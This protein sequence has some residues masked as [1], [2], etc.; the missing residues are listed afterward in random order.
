MFNF[1][2]LLLFTLVANFGLVFLAN[3]E[4]SL[5]VRAD[6][7]A[8]TALS[9][10]PS[11]VKDSTSFKMPIL[12]LGGR[13]T[14]T[15]DF[16][17][18]LEVSAG[19][20]RDSVS[21]KSSFQ[22]EKAAFVVPNF[23]IED[24]SLQYGLLGN[25]WVNLQERESWTSASFGAKYNPWAQRLNYLSRAD[26]GLGIFRAEDEYRIELQVTNG[27]GSAAE[28]QG[29]RKDT[30][31]FVSL[32]PFESLR[33]E[34]RLLFAAYAL[35]GAYENIDPEVAGRE[36]LGI[37]MKFEQQKR[38]WILLEALST[39]DPA[40]GINLKVA[41]NVDVSAQGG[42]S[43]RGS[44][45]AGEIAA[46]TSEKSLISYRY[47]RFNPAQGVDAKGL[48]SGLLGIHYF[49]RQFLQ[50]SISWLD[51]HLDANHAAGMRDSAEFLF[52]LR[53]LWSSGEF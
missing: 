10:K 34:N 19:R 32:L 3:A 12:Y 14:P 35:E 27:E 51:L 7:S 8:S 23:I 6:L 52:G 42:Q 5:A 25:P 15:D 17:F 29:P 24:W 4:E 11:A 18:D 22:F 48:S 44:G 37:M 41:E 49:T 33:E 53:L 47:E 45:Y 36:R 28:E 21:G 50:F 16:Y 2:S 40:D 9:Q 26:L 43:V 30:Q 13:W 20:T 1:K 39:K 46:W 31:L 38:G